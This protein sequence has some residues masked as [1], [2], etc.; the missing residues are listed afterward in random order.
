[1]LQD[2]YPTIHELV[3]FYTFSA[4]NLITKYRLKTQLINE[5]IIRT[6]LSNPVHWQK[7]EPKKCIGAYKKKNPRNRVK[8]GAEKVFNV[9]VILK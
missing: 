2:I 1:M 7:K 8:K 3:S 9:H 4:S 5:N 6:D